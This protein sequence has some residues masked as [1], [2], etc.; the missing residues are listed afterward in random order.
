MSASECSLMMLNRL[1]TNIGRLEAHLL[2]LGFDLDREGSVQS[3][4]QL[5][6]SDKPDSP[7]SLSSPESENIV[8]EGR[9]RRGPYP[10][11]TLEDSGV[12]R[13]FPALVMDREDHVPENI[14]ADKS[15]FPDDF[16]GLLIPRC[17]MGGPIDRRNIPIL[18]CEGLQWMS[19][20][21]GMT[22]RLSS[23][24]HSNATSFGILNDNFP[25]AFCPLPSKEEAASLLYQYLQ[26]FN[27]LC[28]LFEQAKLTTLFNEDNLDTALRVPSCWA[29]VNV[30]F[31]LGIA[32]RVKDR[33][34]A[35]SE[36]QR[37][38][39]FIKNA[40]S[41]FHDLCLGQPDLWSIQALLGMSIFFLGTMSAE[42]CC[43]LA[44]AAIRMSEQI[45]L[46][47]LNEHIT[48][49]SEDM[50]HRRRIFWIA[51]C[52]DREYRA[53]LYFERPALIQARISIRFGRPPTQSDEDISID[54][55]TATSM[56]DFQKLS[57][58]SKQR[59][60]DAFRAH[61]KL[62]T[63]KSQLYKDLYSAAAKDRPLSEIMAS[64]GTLDEMLRNWREDLPPE[65][66]P[67]SYGLPSVS[68]SSVSVML[69]YLHCSYFNCLIAI[70]RLIV[71]RG[72]QTSQD[73]LRK[74]EELSSSAPPPY[75]SRVFESETLC[76]NAA[77][78]SIR[79]LKYMPEGHIS[80]VGILIHYPIVAL[81]TLSSIII[82]N[83]L[84]ASLNDLR[85]MDQ[86][87][88]YLSSLVVSIPNQ[89]IGQLRTYCAK[90][91]AAA[92]AAAQKTMQFCP[93]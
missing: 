47:R 30:V 91:R 14:E 38:W 54:L 82:R 52:L 41:S 85:L 60:F 50:E 36:H 26:N 28:P 39:L 17:I 79:L 24:I 10:E 11:D 55:P 18:S 57:S 32:F 86:V 48:L 40:F 45:G 77:R 21:A 61:C 70:H 64:I 58:T 71:S 73:L 84:G 63:I 3:P 34:V 65:C 46:G 51:Y 23:G 27:C 49:S 72:L 62:A 68:Q 1:E 25:K 20:K 74:Y 33:T 59:E 9:W 87:E 92:S 90:Y 19:Q 35:H 69:L 56:G 12:Q 5:A 7:S 66:R 83:P 44:A 6:V 43:F 2:D 4:R 93:R 22:P 80:L 81:T 37:S 29:S 42:P 53:S 31:A 75:T 67:E 15:P 76:A 89:V 16:G 13:T 78:A 8:E 88:T